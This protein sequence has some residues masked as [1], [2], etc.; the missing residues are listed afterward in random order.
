MRYYTTELPRIDISKALKVVPVIHENQ[1][2]IRLTIGSPYN[3]TVSLPIAVTKPFYGGY[4][5][6]FECPRSSCGRRTPHL[7]VEDGA[8][9][10]RKCLTLRYETQYY[11]K[12]TAYGV[13]LAMYQADELQK[14]GRRLQ[15]GGKPTRIG[16]RY[17]KLRI[18]LGVPLAML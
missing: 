17:M 12:G 16:Q 14:S 15:Y 6:W 10:C 4:R 13:L 8:I 11:P 9:A 5:V 3:S 18:Q 7:Y 2:H 1:G